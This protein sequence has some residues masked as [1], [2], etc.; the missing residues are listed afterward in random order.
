MLLKEEMT[1]PKFSIG[2]IVFLITDMDQLDRI[3]T[4]YIIRPGQTMFYLTQ[5]TNET[6]HYEMEIAT[7]KNWKK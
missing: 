2:Q 1:K 6:V 4:G 7:D 3:V 5:G